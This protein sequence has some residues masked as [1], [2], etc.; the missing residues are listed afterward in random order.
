MFLHPDH[1]PNYPRFNA[2]VMGQLQLQGKHPKLIEAAK[3]FGQLSEQRYLGA[4]Q[5]GSWPQVVLQNLVDREGNYWTGGYSPDFPNMIA[6]HFKVVDR[7]EQGQGCRRFR[8]LDS[9][10]WVDAVGAV[11][12][13]ELMHFGDYVTDKVVGNYNSLYNMNEAGEELERFVFGGNLFIPV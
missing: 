1:V 12:I 4:L 11:L 10:H 5:G 8:V 7:Y 9:D 3:H 2:Y 6:L 13:H